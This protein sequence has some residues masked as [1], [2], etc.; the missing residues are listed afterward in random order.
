MEHIQ[1]N[2]LEGSVSFNSANSL[3]TI[4]LIISMGPNPGENVFLVSSGLRNTVIDSREMRCSGWFEQAWLCLM[5]LGSD[6]R[7]GW[8]L[9]TCKSYSYSDY[10]SHEIIYCGNWATCFRTYLR[11]II[12][13]T[14]LSIELKLKKKSPCKNCNK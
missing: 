9:T 6:T 4:V 3:G 5:S 8:L 1:L 14:L 13:F 11:D 10:V 2:I 7:V 12:H